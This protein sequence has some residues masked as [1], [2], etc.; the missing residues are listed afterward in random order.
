MNAP[1]RPAAPRLDFADLT[2][3]A[4]EAQ[5]QAVG[6][7]EAGAALVVSVSGGKDSQAMVDFLVQLVGAMRLDLARRVVLVTADLGRMEWDVADH[8][9]KLAEHYGMELITVRPR[10]ELIDSIAARG[11]WPSM[12]ARYC[13]SDHKRDPIGKVIRALC[14]ERGWS[15][16]VHCTGERA[17]ESPRRAKL[18]PWDQDHRLGTRT[19]AVFNWRPVLHLTIAQVW[20]RIGASGLPAH[21]VYAEGMRRLSCAFCVF[22]SLGDLRIAKRLRPELF[23]ELVALERRMGHTFRPSFALADLDRAED[24]GLAG[25]S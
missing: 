10:R 24:D 19:R 22:G 17:E 16:V 7:L 3:H 8:L 20:A 5:A 11:M 9:A 2:A 21:P 14:R 13:T 18:G 15:T 4:A 12:K 6:L 25:P 23:A 1:P